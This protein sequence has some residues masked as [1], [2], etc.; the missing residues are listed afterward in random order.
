[1]TR[2][3]QN[4]MTS[5]QQSENR[6]RRNQKIHEHWLTNLCAKFGIGRT[7]TSA[8]GVEGSCA[9]Q[10]SP[11][12]GERS[13]TKDYEYLQP[14]RGQIDMIGLTTRRGNNVVTHS[15][16]ARLPPNHSLM[17]VPSGTARTQPHFQSLQEGS[18]TTRSA[19]QKTLQLR[20]GNCRRYTEVPSTGISGN[21]VSVGHRHSLYQSD[22]AVVT[23]K[24]AF[25][26]RS[27]L[28]LKSKCTPSS[29]IR[30]PSPGPA[31][32][33]CFSG[34]HA[35]VCLDT[36]YCMYRMIQN[37]PSCCFTG[38]TTTGSAYRRLRTSCTKSSSALIPGDP[39]V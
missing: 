6:L 17:A 36:R 23:C 39:Y 35:L 15:K 16:A 12:V 5:V 18:A 4:R 27:P 8:L 30:R 38:R 7:T 26:C 29:G 31:G 2:N 9:N 19:A 10:A 24:N 34:N 11:L 1:L 20:F 25:C 3:T 13:E 22:P 33:G 14:L 32:L 21:G 37:F 28:P